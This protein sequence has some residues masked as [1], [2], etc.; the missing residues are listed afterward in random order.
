MLYSPVQRLG[1]QPTQSPAISCCLCPA[2][3]G[4]CHRLLQPTH[5][6]IPSIGLSLPA[7]SMSSLTCLSTRLTCMQMCCQG[8]YTQPC[9]CIPPAFLDSIA[10]TGEGNG[11]GS[12]CTCMHCLCQELPEVLQ[13]P[14][15]LL[16]SAEYRA[17]VRPSL[18]GCHHCSQ[19]LPLSTGG[20]SFCPCA[21]S[22]LQRSL[23]RLGKGL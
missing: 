4:S 11:H 19:A 5:E 8:S 10:P 2:M 6:R 12:R 14:R 9:L 1:E 22:R 15:L 13:L 18:P 3:Q 21:E 16:P 23:L 7:H 20:S 17:H